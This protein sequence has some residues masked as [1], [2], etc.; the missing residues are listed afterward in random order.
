MLR[1]T[2]F[3]MPARRSAWPTSR[4]KDRRGGPGITMWHAR[5]ALSPYVRRFLALVAPFDRFAPLHRGQGV[6]REET[7]T[8]PDRTRN[9]HTMRVSLKD[10]LEAFEFVSA[11]STGENQAFLC[12]QSGKVYWCVEYSDDELSEL[13]DDIDD[14]EKYV[15]IPDKK[16]LDLGK[17]LVLEFVRQTQP[18]EMDKVRRIFSAKGAY[19]R[20]KDLMDRNGVL[21]RIYA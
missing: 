14:R 3:M 4:L 20:F 13:P 2:F 16:E 5:N 15:Q 1:A 19:A 18:S 10:I 12:R 8:E 17:P 21:G 7:L 6:C 9:K 11:G